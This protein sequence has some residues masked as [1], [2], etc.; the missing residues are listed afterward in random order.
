MICR[1]ICTTVTKAM[2]TFSLKEL[3]VDFKTDLLPI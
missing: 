2:V 3:S 1:D